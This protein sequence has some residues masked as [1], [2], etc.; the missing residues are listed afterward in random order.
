M[1]I[2]R[3]KKLYGDGVDKIEIRD[4]GRHTIPIWLFML[5]LHKSGLK[6]RKWRV[7]KKVVQREYNKLLMKSLKEFG[8]ET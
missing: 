2:E 4:D 1:I 3:Y 7:V 5:L 6:S 8:N